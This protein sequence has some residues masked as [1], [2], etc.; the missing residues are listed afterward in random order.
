[1]DVISRLGGNKLDLSSSGYGQWKWLC[2]H[3][4][5]ISGF[6]KRRGSID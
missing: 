4:N 6:T 2:E 3:A 1:M 5:E